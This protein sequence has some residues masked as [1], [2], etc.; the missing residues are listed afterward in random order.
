MAAP[1]V[2]AAHLPGILRWVTSCN[3]GAAA[4]ARGDFLPLLVG[5]AAVGCLKPE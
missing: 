2:T 5:G 4:A 1:A 3:N